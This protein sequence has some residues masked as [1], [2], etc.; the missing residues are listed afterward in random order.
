MRIVNVCLSISFVN[1]IEW[2]PIRL[3][4]ISVTT[5]QGSPVYVYSQTFRYVAQSAGP[6]EYTDCFS[7]ED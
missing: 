1:K 4:N 7:A 6:I 5:F 2:Q 3:F